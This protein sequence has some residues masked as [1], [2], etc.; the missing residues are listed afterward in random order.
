MSDA[1]KLS[2]MY[3]NYKVFVE[4]ISKSNHAVQ[5]IFDAISKLKVVRILIKDENP[6]EI[7]ESLNSTG[8]ELSNSDLIR[9]YLLMALDYTAQE[10][11]YKKYW[12]QIELLLRS[13]DAVENFMIQYLITKRRSTSIPYEKKKTNLSKNNLYNFFKEY[14][15]KKYNSGNR[16]DDVEKFLKDAYRYAKFYSQCIFNDGTVFEELSALEKKFYELTFLLDAVNAPIILM[17]LYDKYDN[18]IFDE[19]TFINF[20]DALISL[21]FRAKVCQL[22]GISAQFAGNVIARLDKENYLTQDLFFQTLTFGKGTYSFPNDEAFKQALTTSALYVKMK[23]SGC[24]YFLYA[25]EKNFA[26]NNNLPAYDD[27]VVDHVVPQRLNKDWKNYLQDKNELQAHENWRE[28]SGN[29]ILTRSDEKNVGVVFQ[30]KKVKATNSAFQFTRDLEK[31]S[32]WTSKQIQARAKKLADAAVKI[33]NLPEKYQGGTAVIETIFNLD[34]DFGFFTG[35]K[36]DIISIFNMEKKIASWRQFL[37]ELATQFYT[38]D[39]DTFKLAAQKINNLGNR[40]MFATKENSLLNAFKIDDNVFV[41]TH[42]SA[43]ITLKLMK[44]IVENFD[45]ISGTNF[46]SDIWF[47]LKNQTSE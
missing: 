25:L 44:V 28:T 17:Y 20:V 47:T 40:N 46:K 1:E 11:L 29:L 31:Y 36:P 23:E 8:L 16:N 43:K 14:F 41:E 15:E 33:W 35:K 4:E 26:T 21:A 24:K 10:N 27:V 3:L 34:S 12:L 45:E 37:T 22:S 39:P 2:K 5:E 9:N 32:E 6:Q 13:T 18:G 42:L 38:L 7:F 19:T 30:N